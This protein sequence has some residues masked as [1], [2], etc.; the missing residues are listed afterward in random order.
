M[1]ISG[2]KKI[3]LVLGMLIAISIICIVN[4]N[5]YSHI[6]GALSLL[7]DILFYISVY[8]G[9]NGSEKNSINQRMAGIIGCWIFR[10]L[11]LLIYG[12]L[13]H[14]W[15]SIDAL[16]EL[17]SIII[18][19]SYLSISVH[20]N[21]KSF[22]II[23]LVLAAI[24]ILYIAYLFLLYPNDF[25]FSDVRGILS[26]ISIYFQPLLGFSLLF[27]ACLPSDRRI[28]SKDNKPKSEIE[29]YL[30]ELRRK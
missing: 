22:S 28:N 4:P 29:K 26:F 11:I 2:R 5:S 16:I 24:W 14:M 8:I 3:K 7:L 17:S 30:D 15:L 21:G 9:I 19:V 12:L 6:I 25:M 13:F 1:K 20:Y 10:L 23:S 27:F 18:I